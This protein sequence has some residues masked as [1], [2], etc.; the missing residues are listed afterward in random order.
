MVTPNIGLNALEVGESS[1][2]TWNQELKLD[3]VIKQQIKLIRALEM[4]KSRRDKTFSKI[5]TLPPINHATHMQYTKHPNIEI[6]SE[7]RPSLIRGGYAG[8]V[9]HHF[10]IKCNTPLNVLRKI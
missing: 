5:D 1:T 4:A 2:K 9:K 3:Q 8:L 7:K 6:R 10:G